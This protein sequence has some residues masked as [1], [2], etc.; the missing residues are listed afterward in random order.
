MGRCP[1]CGS[2]NTIA[3]EPIIELREERYGHPAGQSSSLPLPEIRTEEQPRLISGCQ[4]FDR[5]LGGGIVPGSLVLVGGDPG[6]GK[7]TLLLQRLADFARQGMVTLYVSGE[8]SLIQTKM[9]ADRLGVDS[10]NLYVFAEINLEAIIR[11]IERI[12]PQIVVIDSIQTLYRPEFESP[13]GSI[14][15]VR[16]CA[17]QLMHVAK[18]R[19]LPIFLVGHVTKEGAIAGPRVLEHMVDALL[20]LEGDRQYQFRILRSVKNRFGPTHELGIFEIREE[21]LVEVT[22]PSEVFLSERRDNIPGTVITCTIEGT[23]PILVEIQALTTTASFGMPQRTATGID[24]RRM[25][26][27]LAVLEKRVG[28]KLGSLDVFVKVAGGLRLD[29]PA[30]DA[31]IALAIASSFR[32][33]VVDPEAVVVGE[34]GLGGELRS[35]PHID[36]RV[37]ESERLGFKRILLPQES[38]TKLTHKGPIEKVGLSSIREAIEHLIG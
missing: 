13:P 32:N 4:E 30:A 3:E 10:P 6:I 1:N 21:G 18:G 35:I 15:Q 37:R 7:S 22:N 11:E 19:A 8:E 34:V 25:A 29:E 26:L 2:W 24:H 12:S 36:P 28:F 14:T 38:L 9:R 27:L 16:E 33:R 31:A 5:V 20:Y 23:R 17:L